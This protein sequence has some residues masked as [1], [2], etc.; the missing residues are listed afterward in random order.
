VLV[1][2]IEEYLLGCWGEYSVFPLLMWCS[3]KQ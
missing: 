1:E 2:I 3:S